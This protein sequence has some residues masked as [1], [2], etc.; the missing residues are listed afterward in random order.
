MNRI[1][2]IKL[3]VV[4]AAVVS[5]ISV[6]SASRAAPSNA[7]NFNVYLDDRK[8]GTHLFE[9]VNAGEHTRVQSIAD[10]KLKVLF[11]AAYSYQHTNTERWANDCLL[12]FDASTRVNGKQ[13]QVSGVSSG[14]G[15]TVRRDSARQVLPSCVM[16]FAY[17]NP[18][19]LKQERL[20]N[21]QTGEY[22]DV[23]VE[24][25]GTDSLKVRG[26]QVAAARYKVSARGIDLVLWYSADDKWLG[27]ESAA[28]GGRVIRY[29]LS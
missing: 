28:R 8:V 29:E 15:F 2:I 18:E 19:F 7:W 17:W 4:L 22:L 1:A 13:T 14:D 5:C 24:W 6:A 23:D 9:V 26:Q 3:L 25:L 16:S 12:E 27:L 11:V 20:L 21:P 10:F